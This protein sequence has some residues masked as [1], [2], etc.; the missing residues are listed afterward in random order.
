MILVKRRNLLERVTCRLRFAE[1][2]SLD[3]KFSLFHLDFLSN[4]GL[5]K[6]C[7][8]TSGLL[9]MKLAL[10]CLHSFLFVFVSHLSANLSQSLLTHCPTLHVRFQE[11]C[12]PHRRTNRGCVFRFF[13]YE[14]LSEI[15]LHDGS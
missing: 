9:R 6:F 8:C 15:P 13:A 2:C 1:V 10:L 11:M 4:F 14:T 12:R 5:Q 3:H 7:T